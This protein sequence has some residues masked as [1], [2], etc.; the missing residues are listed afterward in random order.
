MS[1]L[2][3]PHLDSSESALIQRVCAGDRGAFY[4]LVRPHERAI[5]FSAV[6]ILKNEADAEEVAQ[7]AVLKAFT[8]LKSFRGECKFSTWIIQIT[9]NEARMKLRKDRRH[10]YESIDESAEDDSGDYWPKDYADWRPIPSQALERKEL[11][12]ALKKG[13]ESLSPKYREVFVL[14]DI[15][16]LSIQETAAALGISEANVKVRLL[17]ARLQMRD[18]LAPGF[19][20]AW[21]QGKDWQK[22]R[23]W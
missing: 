12:E 16:N 9:I 7:E 13:M 11:R 5:Y 23:P 4:D 15:Q 8:N 22:V 2:P 6:S 17:R 20:G 3:Q 19:D 21:S 1:S 18:V 14:R 10:L